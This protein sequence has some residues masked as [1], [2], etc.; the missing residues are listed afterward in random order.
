MSRSKYVLLTGPIPSSIG[1][2]SSLQTL[3]IAYNFFSGTSPSGIGIL[4]SLNSIY[5]ANSPLSGPLPSSICH[6]SFFSNPIYSIQL[7]HWTSSKLYRTLVFLTNPT[8]CVLFNS[9]SGSIPSSIG[10]RSPLSSMNLYYNPISGPIPSS[11]GYLSSLQDPSLDNTRVS[12]NY[13][14]FYWSP[15]FLNLLLRPIHFDLRQPPALP[16]EPDS[17][18]FIEVLL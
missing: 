18:S 13:P 14:I 8:D 2:L 6:L 4:S 1:L 10:F 5:I 7:S 15:I 9:F 12:S 16:L 17:T 3:F 11:V